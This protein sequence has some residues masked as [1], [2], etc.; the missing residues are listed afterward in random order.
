M[1]EDEL[2]EVMASLPIPESSSSS[3]PLSEESTGTGPL[4]SE[5][6]PSEASGSAKGGSSGLSILVNPRQV[7]KAAFIKYYRI[8]HK[9]SV[10]LYLCS[11]FF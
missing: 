10:S 5:S 8:R 6:E 4:T 1:D 7:R 9:T 11:S 3:K 2:D